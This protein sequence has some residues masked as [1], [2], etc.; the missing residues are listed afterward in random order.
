MKLRSHV[1]GTEVAFSG[2]Q[3]S[4]A[5]S[6]DACAKKPGAHCIGRKSVT[7]VSGVHVNPPE[8]GKEGT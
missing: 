4:E 3:I 5:L 6:G 2:A 8:D 7:F 1:S